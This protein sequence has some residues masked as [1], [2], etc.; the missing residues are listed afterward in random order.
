MVYTYGDWTTDKLLIFSEMYGE[1]KLIYEG[2]PRDHILYLSYEAPC[3]YLLMITDSSTGATDFAHVNE[4]RIPASKLQYLQ[5][6]PVSKTAVTVIED[7]T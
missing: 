3:R 6:D 1:R 5:I 7:E 4:L 2:Y